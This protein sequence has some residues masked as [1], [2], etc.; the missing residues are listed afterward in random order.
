VTG[1][2]TITVSYASDAEA[3]PHEHED[4]HRAVVEK[5]FEGGIANPG[6]TI[7]VER[8]G[9]GTKGDVVQGEAEAAAERQKAGEGS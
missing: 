4:A 3:L 2:R 1:K 8:D 7:L 6:D 5:L 9:A